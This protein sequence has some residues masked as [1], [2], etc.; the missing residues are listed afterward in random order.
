M[1]KE[2]NPEV[3]LINRKFFVALINIR[4][5]NLHKWSLRL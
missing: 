5:D 1:K 2:E 4:I 3:A